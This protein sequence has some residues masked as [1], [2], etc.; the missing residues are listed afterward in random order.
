MHRG[1][2][3]DLGFLRACTCEKHTAEPV[4]V[5][6]TTYAFQ[7]LRPSLLPPLLPADQARRTFN[8]AAKEYS[9]N[10]V[11]QLFAETIETGSA[12]DL[13]RRILNQ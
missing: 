13:E 7:I 4:Q 6:R 5:R 10:Q 8:Q 9:E 11:K 2:S 3:L 1:R 12:S